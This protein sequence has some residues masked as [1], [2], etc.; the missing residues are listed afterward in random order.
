MTQLDTRI[1]RLIPTGVRASVKRLAASLRLKRAQAA[2]A[3]SPAN[4]EWLP[5]DM[6]SELMREYPVR[7]TWEEASKTETAFIEVPDSQRARVIIPQIQTG[8]KKVLE[9]GG[10]PGGVSWGVALGG[11]D[12]TCLDLMDPLFRGA[13]AAGVRGV[14]GDACNLPFEDN[15]FDAAWSINAFEHIQ[16][17]SKALAEA[18]RVVKPGGRVLL[19]FAPIYC[20]PFGLHA[21]FEIAVPFCQHL[22][23]E[24]QLRP[25][26]TH[27]GFWHLNYWSASQYRAAWAASSAF[28]TIYSCIEEHD[29]HGLEL[30]ER[31]PSCFAKRSRTIGDFTLAK[32]RI[33][34][35]VR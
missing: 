24:D 25:H 27:K 5:I 26:V 35:E 6:L 21:F 8:A 3:Q 12:V 1:K 30:I 17:P 19:D 23:S 16:D 29:Y 14:N 15:S 22:W 34:F 4:P 32:F 31:F 13:A 20:S 9:I 28:A 2:L 7:Q 18:C 33:V 10:G 11:Y